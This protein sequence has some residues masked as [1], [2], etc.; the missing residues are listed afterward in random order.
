MFLYAFCL[1]WKYAFDTLDS[2]LIFCNHYDLT[3][4]IPLY[5]FSTYFVLTPFLRGL[6]FHAAQVLTTGSLIH[7]FRI[8]FLLFGALSSTEPIFWYSLSLLSGYVL[9][10]GYDGALSRLMIMICSVEVCG[11]ICVGSVHMFGIFCSVMALS[12]YVC[13]VCFSAKFC[14]DH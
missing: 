10:S 1:F 7:T 8:L 3:S 4:V 11:Y 2:V 14:S 6:R 12:A 13:Q 5:I 9:C